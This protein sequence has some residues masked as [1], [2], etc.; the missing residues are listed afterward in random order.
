M[1]APASLL[2]NATLFEIDPDLVDEGERIGFLHADKAAAIGRLMAVDGQRDPIKVVANKKGSPLKSW[3]LVTGM[4]RLIGA[5]VEGISV[6]A[7]EVEGTPEQLKELEASE[8]LHRRPLAPI[9]RAKFTAAL[10]QAAQER[11]ARE[12]G[13]LSH[14]KLGAKARW[15]RVKASEQTAQEALA[16]ETGD[17]CATMAQAYGWEESVGEALGM[18]RRSIHRDLELFRLVI[19]PFPGMAEALSK[20]PIVGE[21]AKQLRDIAQVRD[22]VSR[23]ALIEALLE[24]E[25]L[26]VEDAKV[27]L[28]IGLTGSVG[29][30]SPLAS[31]KHFNAIKSG[32]SRL[33]KGD[34]ER[35]LFTDFVPLLTPALKTALRDRLNEELNDAR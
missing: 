21:N 2:A 34:K 14:Q 33:G 19:E 35:F 25:E 17:A 30:A 23:K 27:R 29:A 22:E 16:E 24:D 20:H 15:A 28:G 32:W 1:T 3:R 18:S 10:V 13:E 7:L 6:H 31:Q 4:H 11:I 9:E 8:N 26:S 5:R 12:H